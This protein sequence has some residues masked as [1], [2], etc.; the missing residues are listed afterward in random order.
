MS[1]FKLVVSGVMSLLFSQG[2]AAQLEACNDT[3]REVQVAIAYLRDLSSNAW[4]NKGWIRIG[5]RQCKQA[6]RSSLEDSRMV[7]Y[8]ARDDFGREWSGGASGIERCIL[9]DKDFDTEDCP[10]NSR[11]IRMI[12]VDTNNRSEFSLRIGS[13]HASTENLGAQRASNGTPV[14]NSSLRPTPAESARMETLGQRQ[15]RNDSEQRERTV[16]L[17]DQSQPERTAKQP[18]QQGPPNSKSTSAAVECPTYRE[19]CD[20]KT[21]ESQRTCIYWDAKLYGTVY[22][23]PEASQDRCKVQAKR[24]AVEELEKR[25]AEE[26]YARANARPQRSHPDSKCLDEGEISER[27]EDYCRPNPRC[28]MVDKGGDCIQYWEPACSP[29]FVSRKVRTNRC[30]KAVTVTLKCP[31]GYRT[32]TLARHEWFYERTCTWAITP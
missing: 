2:A 8:Y 25:S 24:F 17:P 11:L 19:E 5:P 29:T 4:F 16:R 15:N 28:K 7:H 3:D 9:S 12:R 6:L 32:Y 22:R 26:R 1:A 18:E 27:G 20:L 10:D 23:S 14:P 13:A 31:D 30:D 21:G